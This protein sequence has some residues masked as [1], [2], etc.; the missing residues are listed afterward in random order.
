M[1]VQRHVFDVRK[2]WATFGMKRVN[3]LVAAL[4][5]ALLLGSS[6][7]GADPIIVTVAGDGTNGLG[8]EGVLAT[9]TQLAS[10]YGVAFDA[11]GNMYIAD[12]GS[13]RIRKVNISDGKINTV[14]GTGTSGYLL[15]EDG[16]PATSAKLSAPTKVALDSSGNIYIADA[17]NNRIRKVNASDGNISTVAGDGS[18]SSGGDG[19][20]ATAA[21]VYGPYGVFVDASGNIFIAEKNGMRVRKVRASDSKIETVAGTGVGGYTLAEDGGP[22][23]SAKLNN[24]SGVFVDVSGTI[25][26]A[27]VFNNRIRK[28]E[29]TTNTISTV[30]G[31]S[32]VGLYGG[33]GNLATSAFLNMPYDVSVD[34][35]GNI[36]I[37]DMSN[38]RIRKVDATTGNISTLAG[39]GTAA[40]TGDN[41]PASAA[42]LDHPYG[43]CV[44][45][46]GVVYIADSG[47]DTIRKIYT[48]ATSSTTTSVP[49]PQQEDRLYVYPHPMKCPG[50]NAVFKM[51]KGGK[52]TLQV[53]N[54]RGQVVKE[55]VK[56][57]AAS[58]TASVP[59]LCADVK[60]GVYL[61]IGEL[62]YSD[63]TTGKLKPY[64]LIVA[65]GR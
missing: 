2:R 35:S 6:V 60:D 33:D 58:D 27:D 3:A 23:T 24:P 42:Q 52:A 36:F 37:A 43:L 54:L 12:A 34:S 56:D 50:G 28:V 64:K 15:A 19:N 20:L 18:A 57:L 46:G 25:Y 31:C 21:Q 11:A 29:A 9:S 51:K 7:L 53:V 41:G 8:A 5:L 63:G 62:K 10:P 40:N 61:I 65:G 30:A 59:I 17:N 39:D 16:G 14:A 47:N 22:A 4:T 55:I 1:Q 49:V 44:V 32:N 45:A 38:Y 48:P 13:N 26:I